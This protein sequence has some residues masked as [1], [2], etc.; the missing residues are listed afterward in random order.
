L[1]RPSIVG[2]K[3]ILHVPSNARGD[4]QTAPDYAD[5]RCGWPR[6]S[7]SRR[8]WRRAAPAGC[9]ANAARPGRSHHAL[10]LVLVGTGRSD[11]ARQHLTKAA[12]LEPD[13]EVYRQTCES[14]AVR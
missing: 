4:H 6:F 11:E 5:A 8:R 2:I 7:W 1:K 14:L 3:A 12:E 13:N 10:G 9:A